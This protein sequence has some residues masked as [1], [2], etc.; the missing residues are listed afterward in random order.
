MDKE[1]ILKK[2]SEN[3]RVERVRKKYSQEKLAEMAGITAKYLNMIENNKA[4]PSI[5]VLIGLCTAL[6]VDIKILFC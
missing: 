2:I 4:N 3:I 6:N 1:L 5:S